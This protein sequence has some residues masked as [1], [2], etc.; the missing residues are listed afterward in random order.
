MPDLA[1]KANRLRASF[2][3]RTLAG[4]AY[5]SFAFAETLTTRHAN[6]DPSPKPHRRL[7]SRRHTRGSQS[8]L[9]EPAATCQ[10]GSELRANISHANPFVKLAYGRRKQSL[11]VSSV[12]L[13]KASFRTSFYWYAELKDRVRR[14]GWRL[15]SL[16]EK[17][18]WGVLLKSAHPPRA[19][20]Q[21]TLPLQA[22]TSA[23]P[24]IFSK[25]SCPWRR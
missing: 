3:R 10:Q 4:A 24:T 23:Q 16:I 19:V 17:T 18:G 21:P 8:W 7:T 25:V 2:R 12:P 14:F 5:R 6:N 9:Q 13:V 20:K 22:A 15:L 1:V 11:S